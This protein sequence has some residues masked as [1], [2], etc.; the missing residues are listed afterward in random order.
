MICTK[1]KGKNKKQ[2]TAKFE[3]P[4]LLASPPSQGRVC[5]CESRRFAFLPFIISLTVLIFI[6]GCHP[7]KPEPNEVEI[8]KPE[9]N[10]VEPP[11]VE[12]PKAEPTKTEPN[13]V[14]IVKPEPN[15][16]EIAEPEPNKVVPHPIV[17]F[18]DKCAGILTSFVDDKG[19]VNYKMLTRKRYELRKL[20]DEFAKLDPNEYSSWSKEDKIAFWLN[21]YNIK[22]LDIVADN[23]PIKSSRWERVFRWHPSSV[24]YIDKNVG[25]IH[26]QKFII[27][28]EEFTLQR[29]EKRFF[30]EEFDEPRVFFAIL[31]Y[32]TLSA[33]PLR[34]E[35]YYGHKLDEQLNDQAK[36]FLSNSC[37]FRID[38]TRERVYLSAMLQPT[39]YG[40]EFSSKYAIDKKFKDQKPATRAVLNF[41]TKCISKQD[42]SFLERENYAVK[43]IIYDWTINDSALKK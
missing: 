31:S 33:P 27:K 21:A 13:E 34:N 9:P 36:K 24:R 35:P 28:G 18:H 23:Y 40:K 20:L 30:Y 5:P 37:A 14:E 2:K 4:Q 1:Q 16:A 7:V 8:T 25:G 10:K 42:V 12:A 32:P 6:I 11:R 29:I 38:R 26:K 19:M 3:V 17:S 39:W 22:M 41:I 43:Y 15:K